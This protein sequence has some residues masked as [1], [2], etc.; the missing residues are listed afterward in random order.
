ME[1]KQSLKQ[2]IITECD[3]EDDFSVTDIEDVEPLFGPDSKL[4]LDSLD[5]LQISM[6]V[7]KQF[8]VRIEG[9]KD[10]R[11]AFA[12]IQSLAEFIENAQ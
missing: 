11:I 1:L 8:K 10:G 6:A 7:L 4:E 12:S 2:L 5:A 9:S 3:K